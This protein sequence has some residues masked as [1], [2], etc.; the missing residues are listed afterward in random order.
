MSDRMLDILKTS[1]VSYAITGIL[2]V[3]LSFGM[4]RMGLSEWQV[5]AG[6]VLIYA[7]ATFV[8]GFMLARQA[9]TRR[10]IWGIGFGVAY[11]AVLTGV[12]ILLGNKE[13]FAYSAM[14]RGVIVCVLAGAIGAFAAPLKKI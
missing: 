13:Q 4:Y 1:V 9:G 10:L 6:I 5:T 14:V 2:L 11:F 12:S 3:V 7:V 8:G